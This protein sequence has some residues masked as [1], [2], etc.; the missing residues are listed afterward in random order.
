MSSTL[1]ADAPSSRSLFKNILQGTTLYTLAQMG[2]R[3]A[4]I[5]LLPIMTRALAPSDY[6]IADLLEQIGTVLTLLLC[7]NFSAGLGY[8]YFRAQSEDERRRVIGTT[9]FGALLLG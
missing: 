1:I 2:Q 5:L 6:G 3:L 4:G 9:V 8:F 7:G